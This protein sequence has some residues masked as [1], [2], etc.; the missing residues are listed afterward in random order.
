MYEDFGS[1]K[2]LVIKM[3]ATAAKGICERRGLGRTRHI[4]SRYLWVQQRTARKDFSIE[5]EHPKTNVAD[6]GTKS[7]D[8][9]RM[10]YLLGFLG[11]HFEVGRS[12]CAPKAAS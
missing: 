7:L 3:D 2:D 6:I 11:F 4:A 10:N 8:E 9:A 12:A 1:K 5:K